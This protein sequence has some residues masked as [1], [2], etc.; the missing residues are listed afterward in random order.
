MNRPFDEAKYKALLEGREIKEVKF[1]QTLENKDFRTDSDFWAKEPK[2]NP[3]L[4]YEQIG[5]HLKKSQYGISIA[6]NED[7]KGY[8]I[9]R[10]N[11][12]HNMFADFTVKKCADI[13]N[14]DLRLFKLNDKD[15]LFNRTNSY[16]WVGRTGIYRK[17]SDDNFVFASYLVRFVPDEK[18]ITPE[19]LT[20]FLNTKYG[21]WDVKRRARHSINQTN[22]NPEEV[23]EI[24]IPLLSE[25]IQKQIQF[26]FETA[27]SKL[28]DSTRI[29][30]QA[31]NLLLEAVG[32]KNFE[33]SK[34][35]TNVKNFSECFQASER[36]DAEFYQRKYDDIES[37]IKKNKNWDNLGN[38]QTKI[39]TGEYAPAYFRKDEAEDLTFYIRSTN[40]KRGQ[41]ELDD[42]YYVSKKDFVRIAEKGDIVTARVGSVGVFGEVRKELEGAIYSDNI[43]CFRLPDS[44]IPSVYTI[45]F[46]T[47]HYFDLIDRLARGSV[48]QRLNQETLKDLIVPYIETETQEEISELI[49]ESFRLRKESENLLEIA[50]R[51]VEIAIEEREETAIEF[52]NAEIN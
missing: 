51:A 47:T 41:I 30:K 28:K 40:I 21:I 34:E 42:N 46:N 37:K 31:E 3:A 35:K 6:M 12:I 33:P 23:K 13:T 36:L 24:E 4:K 7:R 5:K 45:L 18:T 27:Y 29:Y 19:Y 39:D 9:Y 8:P 15:V 14:E 44:F 38:L 20:T 26:C 17:S 52:I 43:L 49:E 22:V 1:S 2:K 50:K 10:M 32:L 25:T 11:E 48:Q 16:E